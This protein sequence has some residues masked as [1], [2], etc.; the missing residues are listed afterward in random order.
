MAKSCPY[1]A[2]VAREKNNLTR[3]ISG[4][5]SRAVNRLPAVALSGLDYGY[6]SAAVY[7]RI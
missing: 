6:S 2:A 7:T 4:A 1:Q 5:N 3:I